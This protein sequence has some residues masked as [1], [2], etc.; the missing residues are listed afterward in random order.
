MIEAFCG[1]RAQWQGVAAARTISRRPLRIISVGAGV[2]STTLLLLSLAREVE[3]DVAV[4]CRHRMGAGPVYRHVAR[5][6]T[7]CARQRLLCSWC[8]PATFATR[9]G[10]KDFFEAPDYLLGERWIEGDGTAAVHPPAH[11]RADPSEGS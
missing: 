2:Q 5:L 4:F 8:A 11:D 3:T 7:L 10:R 1:V 6:E 9:L